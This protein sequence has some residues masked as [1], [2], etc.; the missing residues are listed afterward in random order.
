M[1]GGKSSRMGTDKSWV[2]ING[3][4][5]INRVIDIIAPQV[6]EII[7]NANKTSAKYCDLGYDVYPDKIDG[8][9]GPLSG[10][11][12]GLEN[13]NNDIVLSV[14]VDCPLLPNDLVDK[15]LKKFKDNIDV[16]VARNNGRNHPVIALWRKSL[17]GQLQDSI[18]NGIYKVDL[19]TQ[20]LYCESVNFDDYEYDVFTNVN[21]SEDIKKVSEY[22]ND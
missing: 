6:D 9:C 19:F 14:P 10:V 3:K 16:V 1:A 17:Q 12:A 7:I 21:T 22:I 11:L 18:N 2:E 15:M 20:N 4:P 5:M 8:F 13:G